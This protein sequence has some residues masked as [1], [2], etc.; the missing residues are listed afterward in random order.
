[1]AVDTDN[2][3]FSAMNISCPWRGIA[4]LPSGT[5]GQAARQAVLFMYSG[6]LASGGA[7]VTHFL[8][9]LGVGT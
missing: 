5:I 9:T 6:I 8:A 7:T 3:R 2:K 4:I 1:M